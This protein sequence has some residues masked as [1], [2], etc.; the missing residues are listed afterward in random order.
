VGSVPSTSATETDPQAAIG[1]FINLPAKALLVKAFAAAAG[2][3]PMG[4]E[5]YSIRAGW[6]TTTS[7]PPVP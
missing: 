2:N 1:G 5:T 4:Q 3:K 7:F 6:M